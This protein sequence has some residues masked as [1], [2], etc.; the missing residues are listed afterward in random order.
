MKPADTGAGP[1]RLLPADTQKMTFDDGNV[2]LS[3]ALAIMAVALWYLF[4]RTAHGFSLSVVIGVAG[5]VA[6]RLLVSAGAYHFVGADFFGIRSWI[7]CIL[8]SAAVCFGTLG[9]VM[10]QWA[11]GGDVHGTQR[12]PVHNAARKGRRYQE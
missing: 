1:P 11:R 6:I 7:P 4:D 10:A 8:F 2:Q 5:T 3:L 12:G 9:R